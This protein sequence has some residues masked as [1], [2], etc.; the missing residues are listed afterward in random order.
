MYIRK[1]LEQRSRLGDLL[2]K[3]RVISKGQLEIALAMQTSQGVRL[4]EALLA[5][6]YID[7]DTLT[8]ALRKQRWLRA[9]ITFI[10]LIIAP[11]SPAFASNQGN[12]GKVSAA[13]SE[14]SVTILPKTLLNGKS[15]LKLSENKA[16]VTDSLCTSNLGMAFF[17]L[18]V[19]GSGSEGKLVLSDTENNQLSY[20]VEYQHE[21]SAFK[22]LSPLK[23]SAL[24]KNSFSHDPYCSNTENSRLKIS[25]ENGRKINQKNGYSGTLTVTIAAE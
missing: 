7:Q 9:V 20:Q 8:K 22:S 3:R 6:G 19:A 15:N 10:T 17:Q 18:N 24:Y 2:L 4:G 14:I 23:S 13:S 16:Q 11:F 5:L 1:Q 25:L 21:G 12:S